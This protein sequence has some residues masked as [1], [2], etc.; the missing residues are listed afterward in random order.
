MCG[1]TPCAAHISNRT[2]PIYAPSFYLR[3]SDRPQHTLHSLVSR[4]LWML[5]GT[6]Q[7]YTQSAG[8]CTLSALLS[9]C[10]PARAGRSLVVVDHDALDLLDLLDFFRARPLLAAPELLGQLRRLLA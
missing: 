2:S 1:F 9:P 3:A 7:K 8:A 10:C 6:R 5:T 4:E